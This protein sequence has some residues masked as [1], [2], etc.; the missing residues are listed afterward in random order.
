MNIA[1]QAASVQN[2]CD[3]LLAE[4]DR[5]ADQAIRAPRYGMR[6]SAISQYLAMGYLAH[7]A[8]KPDTIQLAIEKIKSLH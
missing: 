7:T 1:T 3:A 2:H 8:N 5:L 4:M 6:T